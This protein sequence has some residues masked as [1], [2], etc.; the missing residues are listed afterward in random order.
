[1]L[2]QLGATDATIAALEA[3]EASGEFTPAEKAALALAEQMTR[4]AKR[5]DDALWGELK[6]HFMDSELIELVSVIGLFN[7]FNRVNDAL[8]VDITR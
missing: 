1:M 8:Q 7:Y 4:D 2:K 6:L 3:W 5:V